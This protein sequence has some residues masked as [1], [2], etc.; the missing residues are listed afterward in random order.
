MT[1]M[2]SCILV[3]TFGRQKGFRVLSSIALRSL[4]LNMKPTVSV[5]LPV[6]FH[7]LSVFTFHCWGYRRVQTCLAFTW[8]FELRSSGSSNYRYYSLRHLSGPV[9]LL[10]W[11]QATLAVLQTIEPTLPGLELTK[12]CLPLT[13]DC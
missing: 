12:I 7:D 8:G 3:H 13:P 4:S 10:L 6:S 1:C 2:Y 11:L 5:K 9:M